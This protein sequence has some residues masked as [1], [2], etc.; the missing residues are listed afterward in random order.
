MNKQEK[1]KLVKE[2]FEGYTIY[3]TEQDTSYIIVRNV[4]V[5]IVAIKE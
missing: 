4:F 3:D 5:N 1:E 2:A